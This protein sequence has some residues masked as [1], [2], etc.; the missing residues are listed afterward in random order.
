MADIAKIPS[1]RSNAHIDLLMADSPLIPQAIAG[2]ILETF[3]TSDAQSWCVLP[4]VLL[5]THD[6]QMVANLQVCDDE[7]NRANFDH[8]GRS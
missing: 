4:S 1:N 6:S 3:G 2:G 5:L 8:C 7:E